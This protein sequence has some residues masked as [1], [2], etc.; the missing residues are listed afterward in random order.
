[1]ALH[2]V[3]HDLS[4]AYE[5][6]ED[7]QQALR[8]MADGD[9]SEDLHAPVLEILVR[10]HTERLWLACDCRGE[11]G[12]PPVNGP[13]R[14]RSGRYYWRRL[15]P[16][17]VAHAKGCVY[18]SITVTRQAGDPET[19][20]PVEPSDD[21][22]FTVLPIEPEDEQVAEPDA[23]PDHRG[24]RHTNRP[25]KLRQRL[26]ELMVYAGLNR[27]PD[28]ETAN[29]REW[30]RRIR[31][32]A[33]GIEIAPERSL[34][35]LVFPYRRMWR[36]DWI[37]AHMQDLAR[38]WPDG[39]RPQAFVC[40][41]VRGVDD[42]GVTGARGSRLDVASRVTRPMIGGKAVRPPCL[43]MGVVGLA[44]DATSFACLSGHAQPIVA[45]NCPVP[46]E[47]SAERKAFGTLR[48]TLRIMRRE[49][50]A[51][52]F[53]LE[54]PLFETD[55]QYGPCLPDFVIRAHPDAWEGRDSVDFMIEVM[56]FEDEG[57]RRRKEDT[58]QAMRTLGTMC[59]ME[60]N[61]FDRPRG[62]AAAGTNV[63]D[64]IRAVLRRRLA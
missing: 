24:S 16:P 17:H 62:L 44:E 48:K 4:P 51:V 46:V 32:A 10:A 42:Q 38:T 55:T 64:K 63:T 19:R 11:S 21:R 31:Q 59:L 9:R 47:S 20:A 14:N 18:S 57:Y 12:R 36:M 3:H 45:M 50:D 26:F 2:L 37:D 27:L 23:L 54:K 53:T 25:S 22:F 15:P 33:R 28:A 39:H 13:C 61:W 34:G 52:R 1:M 41:A 8:R 6:T 60:A 29:A 49:F 58:H 56:G 43:F 7:E 35:D 30:S 40:G 5:L